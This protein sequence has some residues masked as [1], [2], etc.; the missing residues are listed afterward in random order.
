MRLATIIVVGP[1]HLGQPGMLHAA[2]LGKRSCEADER[3]RAL[4]GGYG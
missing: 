1:D 4:H 2:G 3:G